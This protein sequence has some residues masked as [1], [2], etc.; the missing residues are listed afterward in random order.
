MYIN[1]SAPPKVIAVNVRVAY[2]C[3]YSAK[4]KSV[5]EVKLLKK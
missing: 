2:I 4:T 3:K 5:V 1:L